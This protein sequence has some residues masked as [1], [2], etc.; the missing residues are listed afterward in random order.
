MTLTVVAGV[1]VV[2]GLIG[3][4]LPMLPGPLLVVGGIAVWAVPRHDRVGWI[5]LGVAVGLTVLGA[6]AKYLLPGRKL[7]AAGVPWWSLGIGVALGIV[8]FFVIPVLGLLLGFI[9]GV[10]AAELGRLGSVDAAW[11]STRHA[12]SAA[13]WSILIELG[14]G[15]LATAA[16][17]AGIVVG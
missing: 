11:P 17:I 9:L 4:V 3:I 14:A 13:G 2:V 6:V 5:V 10:F 12:L 8:G 1:L 7:R 15:L 16:W